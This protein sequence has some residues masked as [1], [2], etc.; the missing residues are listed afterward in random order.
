MIGKLKVMTESKE[1]SAAN[2][3]NDV[4][5]FSKSKLSTKTITDSNHSKQSSVKKRI[6]ISC[7]RSQNSLLQDVETI[8]PARTCQ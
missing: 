5:D 3:S 2:E 8:K 6:I 4:K 1:I 7:Y